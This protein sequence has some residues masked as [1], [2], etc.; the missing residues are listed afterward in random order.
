MLFKPT[1]LDLEVVFLPQAF[2][3]R[4]VSPRVFST[5]VCNLSLKTNLFINQLIKFCNSPILHTCKQSGL[6][7]T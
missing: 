6:T 3:N 4:I 7:P 5:P 1:M 2:P